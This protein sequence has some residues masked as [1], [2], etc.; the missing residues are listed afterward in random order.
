MSRS[1]SF[2]L[3]HHHRLSRLPVLL[4]VLV[5]GYSLGSLDLPQAV[6]ERSIS[7]RLTEVILLAS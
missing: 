5:V 1:S 7:I 2:S 3:F 6:L 4:A